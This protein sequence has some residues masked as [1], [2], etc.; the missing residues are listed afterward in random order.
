MKEKRREEQNRKEK[1]IKKEKDRKRKTRKE[2]K[3][4]IEKEKIRGGKGREEKRRKEKH[5]GGT[6]EEH[7]AQEAWG[8]GGGVWETRLEAGDDAERLAVD[9]ASVEEG[10]L[11][12]PPKVLLSF[13]DSC[14]GVPCRVRGYLGG[15]GGDGGKDSEDSFDRPAAGNPLYVKRTTRNLY[16]CAQEP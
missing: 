16:Q 1:K 4:N 12:Q 14:G 8:W 2:K 3:R 5:Y 10:D 7:D 11:Q 15:H 9:A 6:R 13:C